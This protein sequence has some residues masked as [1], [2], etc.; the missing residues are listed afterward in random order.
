MGGWFTG[1]VEEYKNTH[2]P[3]LWG[4]GA[5]SG[6]TPGLTNSEFQDR[7]PEVCTVGQGPSK[8]VD[9]QDSGPW[10]D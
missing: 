9:A 4:M 3:E 7:V 5:S 10:L 2:R 8:G 6:S 1:S